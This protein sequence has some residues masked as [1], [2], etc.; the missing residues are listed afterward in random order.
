[1]DVSSLLA[2]MQR[3]CATFLGVSLVGLWILAVLLSSPISRSK[4]WAPAPGH[5]RATR[6]EQHYSKFNNNTK[7]ANERN[8]QSIKPTCGE[9]CYGPVVPAST[10]GL[11]QY[12]KAIDVRGFRIAGSASVADSALFQ[13]GLTIDLMTMKRRDLLDDLARENQYM[14][15]LA[16]DE[17][18][19]LLPD[20]WILRFVPVEFGVWLTGRD[21]RNTRGFSGTSILGWFPQVCDQAN[22]LCQSGNTHFGQ[23]ICLHESA[24]TLTL[25]RS[26][27]IRAYSGGNL[28]QAIRRQYQKSVVEEG[29][30]PNTY[31]AT[32]PNEYFAQAAQAYFDTGRNGPVAG[33]GVYNHI[34][35][36]AELEEYDP[37]HFAIHDELWPSEVGVEDHECPPDGGCDCN[38]YVCPFERDVEPGPPVPEV[39]CGL[40]GW[41]I[42]CPFTFCG[43]IG[44][45][46]GWC[47]N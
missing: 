43:F 3:F 14:V 11:P 23:N 41:S 25:A 8:V 37:D 22:I 32:T 19:D 12:A 29:L 28:Y 27:K 13:A 47:Y 26:S 5:I 36:R 42:F 7:K 31:A 2:M 4:K 15:I 44:R 16:P 6:R 21:Y 24:H 35:T 1:V 18:I 33:D 20:Y 30:W 10:Q 46:A 40:F 17:T 38:N 39:R 34:D 9:C 45:Y